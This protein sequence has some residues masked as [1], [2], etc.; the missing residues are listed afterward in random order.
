MN[1]FDESL[2]QT[3]EETNGLTFALVIG[4]AAAGQW[5]IATCIWRWQATYGV[6]FQSL[7]PIALAA[8]APLTW[9]TARSSIQRLRDLGWHWGLSVP[10]LSANLFGVWDML[11]IPTPWKT[12]G[13]Y[14][15]LVYAVA[16]AVAL[17]L[18]GGKLGAFRRR[19]QFQRCPQGHWFPQGADVCLYC[20][21]DDE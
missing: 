6:P 11:T 19:S 8:A 5:L 21:H 4:C 9:I 10:A 2:H 3:R 12:I 20:K 1:N 13:G 14:A 7:C 16:F 15:I 17:L 18:P